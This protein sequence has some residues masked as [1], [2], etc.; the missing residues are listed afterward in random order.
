MNRTAKRPRPPF[1]KQSQK[2]PGLESN[3]QPRPDYGKDSYQGSN[4]LSQR[5]ALITGG[6]SGIGR[7]TAFAFICE[8]A[9]VAI[10]YLPEEEPDAREL[11]DEVEK[12]G[13]QILLLPGDIRQEKVCQSLI[14]K[15]LKEFDQLDILIN[16]AAYQKNVLNIDDISEELLER[17]YRTNVFAPF[18]LTKAAWP[19]L[20]T[21]STII[22]TASI[23]AYT[24]SPH[25]MVYATTKAALVNMT[26]SLAEKGAEKGIR[27]N[28]VA[29]GPIWSPLNTIDP[30][31]G[32]VEH[33]GEQS[34]LKR[35]GQPIEVAKVFVFLAS[36]DA[37]F[38]TG[39]VYGVTGGM[40]M[41]V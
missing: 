22:N 30:Q 40:E 35:P 3:V 10:N 11:K 37:S 27:V 24:P 29:P 31:P 16:N 34:W 5:V 15:T 32:Q 20:H 13:G 14:K 33:F 9:K 18:F 4:K 17:T 38:V 25:I 1:K 23:Q 36:D 2:F 39:Q 8:G 19:H 28:A 7:A 41:G 21:G 12:K 6:D 26:K